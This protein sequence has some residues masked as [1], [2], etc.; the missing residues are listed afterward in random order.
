M[1]RACI[2]NVIHSFNFQ[3]VSLARASYSDADII[4]LD[5]PLSAVDAHV[6]KH[7]FEVTTDCSSGQYKSAKLKDKENTINVNPLPLFIQFLLHR[8]L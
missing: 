4:L 8:T 3:R 7:L 5:D 2:K 1:D 6:A